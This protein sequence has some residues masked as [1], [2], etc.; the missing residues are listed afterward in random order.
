MFSISLLSSD[1]YR[2]ES[3]IK[4]RAPT[5]SRMHFSTCNLPTMKLFTIR[6]HWIHSWERRLWHRK[7]PGGKR[8]NSSINLD[9][10]IF[11]SFSLQLYRRQ[12]LHP[13][14][15]RSKYICKPESCIELG[16]HFV[17]E[18]CPGRGSLNV[19]SNSAILHRKQLLQCFLFP[20]DVFLFPQI[21]E[22]VN[23]VGMTA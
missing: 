21:T 10:S 12:K 14:K 20:L 13:Q 17:W 9:I 11:P 4:I 16:N 22:F 18:F 19:P 2:N 1:G 5:H 23:L 15:Q 6:N 8:W 3:T 7:K